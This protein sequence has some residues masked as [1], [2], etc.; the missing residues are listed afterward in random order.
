MTDALKQ[1]AQSRLEPLAKLINE[2]A[3]VYIEAGATSNHHKSFPSK[4][5]ASVTVDARKQMH[6]AKVLDADM[7]AALDRAIDDVIES[8]KHEKGRRQTLIRRGHMAI[9]RLTKSAFYE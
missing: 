1:R 5:Q 7:N 8:V 9:K 3:H 6:Y 2:N 4:F